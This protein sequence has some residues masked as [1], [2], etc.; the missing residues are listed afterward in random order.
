M[1]ET[2]STI[3]G[4]GPT[5]RQ[6]GL[7]VAGAAAGVFAAPAIVRGRNLNEKLN[8]AV[9]GVGGRGGSN[10]DGRRLR[11]HR[12]ALRR[13]RARRSSRRRDT[14]PKPAG[15]ATSASSTTTPANSTRWS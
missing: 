13:L 2:S 14:I 7:A 6:F 8:I 4:A 9:I 10:L 3:R 5:R 15:S 1:G 11:E 12:G